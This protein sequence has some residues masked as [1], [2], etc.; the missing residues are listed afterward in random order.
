MK[1]R[2][3]SAPMSGEILNSAVLAA[4]DGLD[5]GAISSTPYFSRCRL[6]QGDAVLMLSAAEGGQQR[7]RPLLRDHHLDHLEGDR[8][9]VVASANSGSS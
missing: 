1:L 2:A 7:V 4:V 9:D 5:V 6:V 8:L 3:V